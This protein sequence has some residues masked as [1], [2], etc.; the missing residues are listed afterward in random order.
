MHPFRLA[1]AE[2]AGLGAGR[3]S[4]GALGVLRRARLSRHL[5]LLR[6]VR[7][8]VAEDPAWYVRLHALS[9][10]EFRAH[11]ADPMTGLWAARALAAL[12][13]GPPAEP[14]RA[15]LGD[16]P[17][18][19]GHPL[20]VTC[21]GRRLTV[22]LDDR[23]PL[24]HLLGLPAAAPLRPDEVARWREH[25]DAAWTILVTR[26][27]EAA[28]TLA[29][30]LRVIVPAR[31][32][33]LAEGVS[34]TSAEAFGAVALSAPASGVQLAVALLHETQHSVLNAVHGLFELVHPGTEPGYSPWREDPRPTFGILHGGYAFLAVTRFWRTELRGGCGGEAEFEFARWRAAVHRMA[35]RLLGGGR[36]TAAGARLVTALRD[37]VEPWLAEP[38]DPEVVRLADLARAD[39]HARWRLRNLTIAP[40]D[41]AA[42]ARAWRAGRAAPAVASVVAPGRRVTDAGSRLRLIR[43]VLRGDPPAAGSAD[44][45]CVRGDGAAALTA[46]REAVRRDRADGAA[47]SGLALVAPQPALRHRPELVRAAALAA[48]EADIADLAAWLSR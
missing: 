48:P 4:A 36:L 9:S 30:V 1:D 15:A 12:R 39:H 26:H 25:L 43:A 44:A 47:W 19:A 40:D 41:V 31:P 6:E 11:C 10:D 3:P 28:G 17:E 21:A 38:V 46:Y 37:E 24:R 29:G 34:A 23:G 32:D 35:G 14:G 22:R 2:L 20:S 16:L 13:T 18:P 45:A 8:A 42:V 27:P 33:P 7:R 5:L